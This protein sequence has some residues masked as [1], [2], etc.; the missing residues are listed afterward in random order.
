[1]VW[2]E[3]LVITLTENPNKSFLRI[4]AH[5]DNLYKSAALINLT[6][7]NVLMNDDVASLDFILG[8]NVRYNFQY[9]VDKGFYWSFGIN[10]SFYEFDQGDRLQH[11]SI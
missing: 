9:Y 3:D 2:H 7:K 6:K 8:D 4:A 5:Y 10:S 11:Y 1:M